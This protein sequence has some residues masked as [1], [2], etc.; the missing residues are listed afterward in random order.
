MTVATTQTNKG[1]PM[2]PLLLAVPL[3]FIACAT[4]QT[5][6][7]PAFSAGAVRGAIAFESIQKEAIAAKKDGKEFSMTPEEVRQEV[8]KR[9]I[10]GLKA[11][12]AK[13]EAANE[14]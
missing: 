9:A 6:M 12:L 3:L 13:K 4:Q 10:E 14:K 2:K 7:T 1:E 11:D 5:D 8:I